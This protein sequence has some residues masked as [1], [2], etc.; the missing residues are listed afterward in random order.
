MVRSL[1]TA[2]TGMNSQQA[3]IDTVANNLSNAVSK[4]NGQNLRTYSIKP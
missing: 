4:N 3:N 2:A 1:W